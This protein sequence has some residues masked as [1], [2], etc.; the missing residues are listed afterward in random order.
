MAV[1][2]QRAASL[3]PRS[4]AAA[5]PSEPAAPPRAL[6]EAWL[7]RSGRSL[8][9]SRPIF[10]AQ[11]LAA[12]VVVGYTVST[13]VV[14]IPPSGYSTLWDGWIGNLASILPLI[15]IGI[16]VVTN[17]RQRAAWL[18]M[19]SGI[20]LYNF[21][22]LIYLWHDQNLTP[23][24][25]PAPS[26]A[27]YLLSYV[28]FTVGVVMLTQGNFRAV[29]ISTRLDGVITGLAIGA[30]AGLLWFN[31]VLSITGKP[32]EVV[33][34]MAY[35]LM[36]LVM[37][38]VLFSALAPM[39]YRLHR[40]TALLM[41]GLIVFVVGDIIYLN[42][43]A[44]GTY[45]QGTL[46]DATWVIGIWLMAL[47]SW[48]L[49]DRRVRRRLGATDVP[50]G[51]TAVPIVFGTVSVIVLSASLDHQ[52]PKVASLMAL[53]AIGLVIVRMAMTLREVR[54]A[55]KS[56]Y[57]TARVDELTRL[58][59]RRAFFEAGE[60][61]FADR[62]PDQRLGVVVMDLNGFKEINDTLGHAAGDELLQAVAKRFSGR[63]DHRGEIA[64]I[65][66]DEFAGTFE[67]NSVAEAVSI[68]QELAGM[69]NDP[70]SIDGMTVRVGGSVGVAI[71]PEHGTTQSEL[72]RCA[73]IA[74][75]E[76]KG[77]HAAIRLYR[78]EDD[79]HTRY[80]LALIDDLR[81]TPWER[82]LL[83]HFQPTLDLRSGTIVGVE[84]LVRWRHPTFGL[85]YPDDYIPLCERSG[86]IRS[87]TRRVIELAVAELE[88]LDR[89]GF[90]LEMSANISRL[91]LLDEALPEYVDVVLARHR[92]PA[93]RLTLEITETALSED[94]DRATRSIVRLRERGVRIAIDDFGVGYSSLSQL[95]ELPVD[96]LKIDKNF[97][98]AL[99]VDA[100]ARA[101]VTATVELARALGL[102]VVAEGIE[103][104]TGLRAVGELGVDVAQG[105]YVACPYTSAQLD[106]YL[107]QPPLLGQP[108][109]V[110]VARRPNT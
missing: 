49:E 43:Q 5:P 61:R 99:A 8:Y 22:N 107:A 1:R 63:A 25:V 75:Y 39:R 72:L 94:P 85:L 48:P 64:R 12:V 62:P 101:V 79:G 60:D 78:P 19:G 108:I 37:L 36:D 106:G 9:A 98:L 100:R 4:V 7:R 35:P 55:E 20:L 59:N 104:E 30:A 82:D 2:T 73:D 16:R 95:L 17:P 29:A 45:V 93:D 65:G 105:Y 31:N 54:R 10:W 74:M 23:I 51:I 68:A 91:D 32:I 3:A 58:S 27:A 77:E 92:I 103:S 28:F 34:G 52:T 71:C 42:Q 88:R 13:L 67:I 90:A 21:G 40:S 110:G 70:I 84:A 96:E 81:R 69:F 44:A 80:R 26:D 66:G 53:T 83:L 6:V 76:A 89:N 38:V 18:V 14:P 86:M 24:P 87:L 57:S 15:P 97:V 47:A 109:A 33:V 56:N 50:D 11:L 41:L 46:L 102:T